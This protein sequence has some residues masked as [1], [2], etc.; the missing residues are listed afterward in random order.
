MPELLIVILQLFAVSLIPVGLATVLMALFLWTPLKKMPKIYKTI[1]VS[2]LFAG[3]S[4]LG[5]VLGVPIEYTNVAGNIASSSINVRDASPIIAGLMFGG[6]A[7]IISGA[8]SAIYRFTSVYWSGKGAETQIA[9]SVAT[10]MAGIFTALVRKFIFNN[11]HGKWYYGFFLGV[12]VEDFHMLLVFITHMNDVTTAYDIV[13]SCAIPMIVTNSLATMFA[14]IIAS[15]MNKEKLIDKGKVLKLSTKIQFSLIA[16]LIVAYSAVAVF[17]YFSLSDVIKNDT[18]NSIQMAI[19]DVKNQVDTDLYFSMKSLAVDTCKAAVE[20]DIKDGT[21]LWNTIEDLENKGLSDINIVGT[22]NIVYYC[23]NHD[24]YLANWS[25]NE[26]AVLNTKDYEFLVTPLTDEPVGEHGRERS[27]GAKIT[28]PNGESIGYVQFT[29][30][31][32]PY[33]NLLGSELKTVCNFRHIN[34]NGFIVIT[35]SNGVVISS[36]VDSKI[37]DIVDLKQ[38]KVNQSGEYTLKRT[39]STGE[40]VQYKYYTYAYVINGY[41][42]AGFADTDEADLPLKISFMA[43]SLLE[44]FVFMVLYV[45]L[46][47]VIKKVAVDKIQNISGGLQKISA[48][49]LNVKINVRN[50][51]E[52]DNLSNDINKTVDTLKSYSEREKEKIAEELKFAKNIQHSVLPSVFPLNDKYEIYASMSTAKEVGGDFYDFYYIDHEHLVIQIADVSGKGIPAAMFMMQAKS[53]IK[54]LVESGMPIDEAYTEANKRLCEGNDAQMFVTAWLGVIDLT[55]G[56]VEFVN[57]GHNPPLISNAEGRLEYLKSKRG[58]VLAGM[59][60]FKYTKQ[61]FDIRPGDKIYLYTDGVTEAMNKAKEL[62]GEERLHIVADAHRLM[63]A[64][65]FCQSIDEDLKNFVQGAEQSDD[66][67]MLCFQLNGKESD[68]II[69]TEAKVENIP[70]ITEFVDNV[71]D[72]LECSIKAKMQID[73]AIDEIVS[74]VCYYAYKP[75][76]IGKVKVV[77]D[78]IEKEEMVSLM[79]E[80]RGVQYNPLEK[81]DPNTNASIEEREI[82][83]LGIFIVKKT[84]DSVTYDNVNGHNVLTLKKKIK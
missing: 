48:G 1:L 4:I 65:K 84:M 58:F 17:S 18:K 41:Y 12:L 57:A 24:N 16:S 25:E 63:T 67:T 82:G 5:S 62:Y 33:F 49:D 13:R 50:V 37:Q 55:T 29:L 56:H 43:I 27:A 71:L 53:I 78:Y 79:F 11:H 38:L 59:D 35:N 72:S 22:D 66:I 77:I 39:S 69:V 10:L 83:G 9:C 51:L 21:N 46:L 64:E 14:L 74:N 36:A 80:D 47:I 42:V 20:K 45:V 52:F 6:P 44:V 76:Q 2:V 70:A 75:G 28:Q 32:E 30:F 40:I 60:K 19:N 61:S 81:A 23:S 3:S 31:E 34:K 73:V 7:G 26:F 15:I 8:I 54:S 68:K